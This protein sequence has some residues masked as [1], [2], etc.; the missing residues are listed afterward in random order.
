MQIATY[1]TAH[2]WVVQAQLSARR[3][4][5]LNIGVVVV[6]GD[7]AHA[8]LAVGAPD[9][10]CVQR[11]VQTVADPIAGKLIE[12]Q[13]NTLCARL[14]AL[15]ASD[16]EALVAGVEARR[17]KLANELV[18]LPGFRWEGPSAECDAIAQARY[19]ELVAVGSPADSAGTFEGTHQP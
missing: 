17:G 15:D 7:A 3:R 13:W 14:A 6:V 8:L 18:M 12:R 19:Q 4:E 2:V 1:S 9:A 16:V 5:R 11:V 10:A